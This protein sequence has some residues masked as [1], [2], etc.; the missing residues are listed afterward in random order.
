MAPDPLDD[1]A[2]ASKDVAHIGIGVAVLAFQKF[3]V[4]RR[5]LERAFRDH[6]S[7]PQDRMRQWIRSATDRC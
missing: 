6:P 4:Q 2:Q 7:D 5:S 3:Q 1:L